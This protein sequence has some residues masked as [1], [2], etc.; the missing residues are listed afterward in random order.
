MRKVKITSQGP[1]GWGDKEELWGEDELVLLSSGKVKPVR[2]LR[3]GEVT[4]RFNGHPGTPQ[5]WTV[6]S[7]EWQR[8]Q[9]V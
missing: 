1:L 4:V 5:L 7:M 6:L 9:H 8:R 2:Q 3:E